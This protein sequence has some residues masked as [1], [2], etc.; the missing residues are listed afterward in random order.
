MAP[1]Y[2]T[3]PRPAKRPRLSPPEPGPYVLRPVLEDIP[4]TTEEGNTD[5]SITCVEYWDNYLYIGTSAGEIL[6]L[7]SIP[8]E[9]G[10]ESASSTF[11]LASRLQPSGH[12]TSATSPDAPGVQQ[13]L[14]LPGPSKACVLCNG[15]VSFYSLPELS[16]A[17][18]NK[19]PTG[20]QWIGGIDENADKESP[21]GPVVMIANTK[22]IL[23]VRV[24][25]RLRAVRNNIEFP[26]CLRSS[27]R[28]TIACVAD[29]TGYA[30]LEV[31]HQQKIPL[32]PVSSLP[33]EEEPVPENGGRSPARSPPPADAAGH[34]RS[35][36][37]GNLIS[38]TRDS[39]RSRRHDSAHLVPPDNTGIDSRTMSPPPDGGGEGTTRATA[40]PRA[41]T[42]ALP[43]RS[44][45]VA[46]PKQF[47]K[48]LKPH[49]LSPF[50]TEFMLTTGTTESE[51]GVGLFV[52][53]DGDVVRGTVDF[54]TYPE[55]LLVDNFS[56]PEYE[57]APRS[58]DEGQIIFALLRSPPGD[59]GGRKLEL[60]QVENASE[61]AH[62][63]TIVA[64]PQ[65]KLDKAH[66]GLQH[67]LSTHNHFFKIAGELLQLVPLSL[68][69][70]DLWGVNRE[71]DPRTQSAV[72]Q[73]EQERALFDSQSLTTPLEP[74]TELVTKRSAEEKAFAG[75]FG[76]A[77]TRNL[78]WHG[79]ELWMVLQNPLISQLEHRLMQHMVNEEPAEV[80][81]GHIFG[82]LAGIHGREPK[83][84]TE[85]LTL[86]YVR[87]KASLILFL[88]LQTR[89]SVSSDLEDL[90]RAVENTLHDGGLDPRIVLLLSPPL[91]SEVLYGPDG[92]WLH[93]GMADLL[94][95]YQPPISGFE[96]APIEYWMMMRHFLMLWQE[97][98]GY[99]SI[100]DDKYV[101]DSVDA[102]LLHVLLHLDQTLPADS[103]AQKSVRAKL[104]NVVDHW[105][106]N[107]DRASSLL[108]RY[109]R[110]FVLSR[111]YQSKKQARDVLATWKRILDGEKDVDYG[112]NVGYIEGQLRRYLTM[113][114]DVE[115][116]QEYA[117]LLAQRNPEL[118]VQ[119]FTDD[120]ARVK[121][122]PHEVVKLLKEHAPGAV[123]QYLEYLVF[124]KHLDQ[125]ADDLIGYYLDSV[126]TVLEKSEAA[127]TSLAES[128]ST[129]RALES[130]K[131]TY[132]DFIHQNAPPEPWWQS[133][134][135]LLQLLGSGA[136]ATGGATNTGKDLTY[137]VDM[138]LER[139]SPFSTYLVS[140]SIILDARQGHHKEALRLLTH[141]LGDYD[142]ATRYCYFGGPSTSHAYPVDP[143]TLPSRT[144]QTELF[145]FLFHE[146]LAIESIED[147]L[148]RTSHLLGKF[149]TFFD[150]LA[151]I[152]SIPDDWTVGM[153]SE[154]LVRSFRAATSE[155]NQAVI[156]KALSA[157]Q[158][159]IG[160]VE[161]IE[162]T[163]KMAARI[164]K[165]G[166]DGVVKDLD[167]E[168]S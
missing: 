43:T 166:E 42:D 62:P 48:R 106:G 159:L 148:E 102:S 59:G 52:N 90:F 82:F 8:P 72:E 37:M 132:L 154:F 116:V 18:P 78:V 14:V 122:S 13:I 94:R 98:R 114:R 9:P 31:E 10:D 127:R 146:F 79:Q 86:N 163:E 167:V 45:T 104:H 30:L 110:L 156:V 21:E 164:E 40:R 3:D 71:S 61:L 65:S 141:G 121:F 67:V 137:S 53:L 55:D 142:T 109:N 88:H 152:A 19:E 63:R 145:T 15:V 157:A 129:Y 75:R 49:I 92:M 46:D 73:L 51:P 54:E 97:K 16:P 26:G 138:V 5:V 24:G 128:Y 147:R 117:L 101:F 34:S 25:D 143:S 66:A 27:R 149:A 70:L 41:S 124:G 96:D 76:R 7:V 84:E 111:L 115:L 22:R 165:V 29:D 108:E 91:S 168:A 2:Q 11:I 57:G 80:K 140:E 131:P 133:R 112:S 126:L 120:A 69:S 60:Q 99:G 74:S 134:L 64:L 23:L 123:Q 39:S 130:P 58:E 28:D 162:M 36:S 135:R 161:F 158:N 125:Y 32:F 95:E 4:L 20:V 136:Y 150:P 33:A 83:D 144:S 160:Q 12:S 47:K 38:P 1:P 151:I 44:S 93:Q 153:L 81:P 77:F 119:I 139:L 87:Q 100:T 155:R 113:I 105:K 89:L 50:S 35:T 85:F 68:G 107:F 56:V 17:F 6:H 103:P 118:A